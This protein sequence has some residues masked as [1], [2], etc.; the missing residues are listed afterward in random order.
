MIGKSTLLAKLLPQVKEHH[1]QSE[2]LVTFS[3]YDKGHSTMAWRFVVDLSSVGNAP[4]VTTKAMRDMMI[5][6]ADV[7]LL[8]FA[9]DAPASFAH[10]EKYL[11]EVK[12]S[13]RPFSPPIVLLGL[14]ADAE[15][16]V[17]RQEAEA[18]AAKFGLAVAFVSA[19]K[20]DLK[21]LEHLLE[22]ADVK[23]TELSHKT[24]PSASNM[25]MANSR[26]VDPPL[27]AYSG[28]DFKW[29]ADVTSTAAPAAP[30]SW[31]KNLLAK[32]WPA[33]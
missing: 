1:L 21:E 22:I 6:R 9:V 8:T 18:F 17:S 7:I 24:W 28:K 12:T 3:H 13:D 14:R 30:S 2:G 33:Q 19:E 31:W 15:H 23:G 20:D 27:S 11:A 29:P 26:Q 5:K 32:V 4:R 25:M 16:A 10:V